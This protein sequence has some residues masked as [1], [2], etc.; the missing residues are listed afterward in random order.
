MLREGLKCL[1]LKL[2]VGFHMNC[3]HTSAIDTHHELSNHVNTILF[4]KRAKGLCAIPQNLPY[5]NQHLLAYLMHFLS[6]LLNGKDRKIVAQECV[7]TYI[8]A[9]THTQ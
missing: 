5:N 3:R 4:K 1:M 8:V 9:C 2:G 7:C 6:K